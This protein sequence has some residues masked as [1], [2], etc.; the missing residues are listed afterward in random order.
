M[1]CFRLHVRKNK[2]P[3]YVVNE[4]V[5]TWSPKLNKK[6]NSELGMHALELLTTKTGMSIF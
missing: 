5:A 6:G 3:R 4:V 2:K 1:F